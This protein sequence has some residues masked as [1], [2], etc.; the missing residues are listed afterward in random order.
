ML[1]ACFAQ[2]AENPSAEILQEAPTLKN[3]RGQQQLLQ[4]DK[5]RK[6]K[7]LTICLEYEKYTEHSQSRESEER[8]CDPLVFASKVKESEEQLWANAEWILKYRWQTAVALQTPAKADSELQFKRDTYT[9]GTEDS[10][11]KH[12][13]CCW[14]SFSVGNSLK[15]LTVT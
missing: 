10:S 5:N 11:S 3:H 4:T 9:G 2:A 12:S 7:S 14:C 8:I 1:T 13:S 6:W 15:P